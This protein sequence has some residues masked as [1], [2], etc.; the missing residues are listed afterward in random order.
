MECVCS[1]SQLV[2]AGTRPELVLAATVPGREDPN[3]GAWNFQDLQVGLKAW[4]DWALVR[5]TLR[6]REKPRDVCQKARASM[7]LAC[8]A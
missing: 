8:L 2:Q 4:A 3:L 1:Q 6:G 7:S 5:Y